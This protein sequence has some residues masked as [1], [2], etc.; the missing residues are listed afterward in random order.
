MGPLRPSPHRATDPGPAH[1]GVPMLTISR[2]RCRLRAGDGPQ[3]RGAV[4]AI[5]ALMIV[6]LL[7]MAGFAIDVAHWYLVAN[8]AQRAA[9]AGALGGVVFMPGDP[10]QATATARQIAAHNGFDHADPAVT[11]DVASEGAGDRLR[12]TVTEVV[13]NFFTGLLGVPTTRITRTAV[14]EFEGPIP[15][16]SPEFYLGNDTA[17]GLV[18]E[19]WVN[20]AASGANKR[21]GDRYATRRCSAG[22]YC[23]GA[24]QPG[25]ENDEYDPSG[26]FFTLRVNEVPVTGEPIRFQVYDAVFSYVGDHCDRVPFPSAATLSAWESTPPPGASVPPGFFSD[27]SAR[28]AGGSTDWCTGDQDIN[29]RNMRTRFQVRYPDDTPWSNTD[30]PVVDIGPSCEPVVIDPHNTGGSNPTIE[31]ELANASVDGA[32][33]WTFAEL[34][35]RYVTVCEIPSSVYSALPNGGVGDWLLQIRGEDQTGAEGGHNRMALRAGFASGDGVSGAGVQFFAAGRLPIYA[36]AT[37]AST[38]FHLARVLPGSDNRLLRVVLWDMGDAASAG[39][40]QIKPPPEWEAT[41][42]PFTGCRF[43]RIEPSAEVPV[44]SSDCRITGVSSSAG[45]NGAIVEIEVP[46]P[47]GYTCDTSS[48]AGCWVKVIASFPGGVQDTTTW[49]ANMVGDP[50][51]LVE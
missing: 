37:G 24:V 22:T 16:G 46:I 40:L 27:A 47:T 9:D 44:A 11:V 50:V 32:R 19:F 5:H 21:A 23:T 30:N 48:I 51:R 1:P 12:V 4:L 39:T 13:P 17:A 42:G 6:V 38:T 2:F 10:S 8:R 28:Y 29:G 34:F 26:Y 7:G 36:N 18:P 49:S 33:P 20:V 35:R 45:Y 15:M 3:D 41:H 25:I 14:A 31:D 43:T